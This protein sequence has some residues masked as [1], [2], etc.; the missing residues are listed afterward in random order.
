MLREG[1]I[2]QTEHQTG[3]FLSSSFLVGKRDGGN[4]PVVNLRYLK[5]FIPYQHFKIEGLFCLREL[6]QE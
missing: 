1:A 3:E 4:W 6:L 5:Q 2:Q